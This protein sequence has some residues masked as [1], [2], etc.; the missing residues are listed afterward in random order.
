VRRQLKICWRNIGYEERGRI[1]PYDLRHN[2]AAR[3]IMRWID[4][5]INVAAMT[6]YLS[7]YMGHSNFSDTLYYIHLL[8]ENLIKSS[9][10][11]WKQF[12]HIYGGGD[13]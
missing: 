7:A 4:E 9:G 3:I 1:R 10:I 5:G 13:L 6:S 12:S 11:D 2:F 8:P